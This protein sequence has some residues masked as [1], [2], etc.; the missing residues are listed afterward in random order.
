MQVRD[1]RQWVLLAA[2]VPV[3]VHSLVEF[4]FAYAYFLFTCAALLGMLATLQGGGGGKKWLIHRQIALPTMTLL[5]SLFVAISLWATHD[6]LIAEE[7]YRVMRFEMRKVGLRPQG[8]EPAEL[9]LLDQLGE[10]L[11]LGRILPSP[12]TPERDI[13]RFRV[14]SKSTMWATAQLRYAVALGLNGRPEEATRQLQQMRDFYGEKSYM[15]AR[16]FVIELQ[17]EQYPQLAAIKLP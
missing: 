14:A 13:E 16:Q 7:D 11:Q 17:K 1:A 5:L 10:M 12:S 4:P 2:V 8:H 15:Q 3:L 9:L 6:Y